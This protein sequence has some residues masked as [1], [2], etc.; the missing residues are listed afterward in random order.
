MNKLSLPQ[1]SGNQQAIEPMFAELSR[2]MLATQQDT[3]PVDFTKAFTELCL[4]QSCGKCVPC[5]IGLQNAVEILNKILEGKGTPEDLALLKKTAQAA[6]ESADC[7]IGYHAGGVILEGLSAFRSD[8]ESHIQNNWCDARAEH[9]VPC[10]ASCP[11]HVDIPGYT[12]LVNAG[13]YGDAV[14]LIRKDNPFPSVCG[15]ICEHPCE[16]GCRR[17]MLDA[18]I[19]IRG[20]K[21]YA[22]E[23][24]G[25]VAPEKAAEPTGKKVAVIGAGPAGLTAAYYLALM[26]HK[27]DVYEKRKVAGGMLR[28]GI[29]GYRLPR[30]LLQKEVDSILAVGN[31]DLHL[32]VD[33]GKDITVEELRKSADAL[34]IAIGAHTDRKLGIE[35]ENLNNVMSA[36]TL[37]RGIGDGEYPDFTGKKVAV[38]GG[39]NVAMDSARSAVRLGAEKVSIVY[40]RRQADMTA[41]EEEVIG[42][43]AD[44]CNLVT[45]MAPARLEGDENGNVKA[46]YV[47]PQLSGAIDKSGRPSVSNADAPEVRL[48]ADIVIVA[49]GQAIESKQF[50][51]Y[52]LA[53]KRDRLASDRYCAF[54]E[55][56][57]IFAGGDCAGGPA[58][59]ILA[60]AAGKTAARSIDSYLGFDHPISV[61]V[62]I[63]YASL[64]DKHLCG[65]VD[66]K[67]RDAAD[68]CHDF[69]LME[70]GMSAD[71]AKQESGRCLRCDRFGYGSFRGGRCKKW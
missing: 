3:C 26:G 10:V 16:A 66:M 42:A 27:V 18:P 49:I 28:Y 29:P 8:F 68:R 7:A 23:N 12:A 56:E 67:E 14:R 5:R 45:M 54:K 59:V 57:G 58:T 52:G 17:S 60:I 32:G 19:N 35:G 47:K 33:I 21:R 13:R 2:R 4:A 69:N 61:D 15:F 25:D 24:A 22:V 65:R 63:P 20:L 50:G 53:L 48:D 70:I 43:M 71:E 46:L 55:N 36:V 41:L 31:I 6:V 34:F 44:G 1:K 40:R 37:L 30:E 11:A 51:D 64:A 38:I 39:G 9:P 62:D